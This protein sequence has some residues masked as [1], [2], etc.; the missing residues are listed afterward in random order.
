[1]QHVNYWKDIFIIENRFEEL[2]NKV[3]AVCYELYMLSRLE[4]EQISSE[5]YEIIVGI[6]EIFSISSKG[7][8]GVDIKKIYG[9]VKA[10]NNPAHIGIGILNE[11]L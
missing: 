11:L 4:E 3:I 7:P 2:E 8:Q 9:L 10:Y 6:I 1:M 5:I